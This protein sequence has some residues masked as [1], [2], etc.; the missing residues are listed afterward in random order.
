MDAMLNGCQKEVRSLNSGR[1]GDLGRETAPFNYAKEE[2][3]R[4]VK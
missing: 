3:N 1:V 2:L 4:S